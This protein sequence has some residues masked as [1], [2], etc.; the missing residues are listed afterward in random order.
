M[1]WVWWPSTNDFKALNWR[2]IMWSV[3]YGEIESELS[4]KK[5][6]YNLEI[7]SCSVINASLK[8]AFK[9]GYITIQRERSCVSSATAQDHIDLCW[10]SNK[11]TVLDWKA[12]IQPPYRPNLTPTNY[13]LLRSLTNSLVY[14]FFRAIFY[15]YEIFISYSSLEC[16]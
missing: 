2:L 5:S 15:F 10:P 6:C 8:H 1:G 9:K 14:S 3:V 7:L 4:F 12:L 11:F 16:M 13:Y